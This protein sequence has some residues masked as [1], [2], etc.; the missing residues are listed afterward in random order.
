MSDTQMSDLAKAVLAGDRIP[1]A[2]DELQSSASPVSDIVIP[3]GAVPITEGTQVLCSTEETQTIPR[4]S[5]TVN[6]SKD[7]EN[8]NK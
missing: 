8:G 4:G 6:F 1:P 2:S 7:E 5:K 3:K